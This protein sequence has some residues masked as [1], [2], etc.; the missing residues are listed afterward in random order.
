MSSNGITHSVSFT[1]S[2]GFLFGNAGSGETFRAN[3]SAFARW[4]IV[5]RMLRD[6]THRDIEVSLPSH[7]ASW[8]A[9]WSKFRWALC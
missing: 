3:R 7:S 5:P 9:P 4:Q 6:V 8:L 1:G 2:W